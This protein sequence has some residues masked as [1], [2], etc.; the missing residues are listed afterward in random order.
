[1]RLP[2][3]LKVSLPLIV[4]LM[5][6]SGCSKPIE[7]RLEEFYQENKDNPDLA[8]FSGVSI[9]P[10]RSLYVVK[11]WDYG[12]I[13]VRIASFDQFREP[14]MELNRGEE[15]LRRLDEE[16]NLDREAAM[17]YLTKLFSIYNEL[18]VLAIYGHSQSKYTEFLVDPSNFI[19]YVP[20][21]S[22]LTERALRKITELEEKA[23]LKFDEHWFA[24]KLDKPWS[25]SG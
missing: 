15:S 25:F 7:Q 13:R 4:S 24:Y 19:V 14:Q 9:S 6:L 10:A 8:L 11:L 20:D 23:T 2:K 1:M 18:E 5:L 17:Q 12:G 21:R 16:F 22:Q 3:Y